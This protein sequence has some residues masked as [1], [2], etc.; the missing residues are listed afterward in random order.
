MRSEDELVSLINDPYTVMPGDWNITLQQPGKHTIFY[1]YRSVVNGRSYV[2]DQKLQELR[3]VVV[4][5]ETGK[6]LTLTPPSANIFYESGVPGL[7]R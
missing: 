1:E 3:G 5:R 6:E 4:S 7:C 2:T